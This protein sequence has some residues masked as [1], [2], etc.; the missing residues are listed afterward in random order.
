VTASLGWAHHNCFVH[1]ESSLPPDYEGFRA[2]SALGRSIF[3]AGQPSSC[4]PTTD[5]GCKAAPFKKPPLTTESGGAT[6]AAGSGRA[7]ETENEATP[8]ARSLSQ[9]HCRAALLSVNSPAMTAIG[10]ARPDGGQGY[11]L[12]TGNAGLLRLW[13]WKAA[14][15]CERPET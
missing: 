13:S 9:T 10:A 4:R 11:Q 2:A 6:R 8:S 15:R 14:A 7:A 3:A 1:L 12:T 5:R